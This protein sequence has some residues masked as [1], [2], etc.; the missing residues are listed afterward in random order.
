MDNEITLSVQAYTSG[1]SSAD[2]LRI[3]ALEKM[4]PIIFTQ[5][6]V[7]GE[8]ETVTMP[9][10]NDNIIGIVQQLDVEDSNRVYYPEFT[11]T[12]DGKSAIFPSILTQSNSKIIVWP[13]ES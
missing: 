2:L 4:K 13:R 1:F 3:T 5:D 12:P 11:T 6:V 10:D 8:L 7:L 9:L